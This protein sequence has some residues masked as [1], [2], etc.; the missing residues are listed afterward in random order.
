MLQ[1]ILACLLWSSAFVG[2][3]IGLPYTT[4]LQFAG[5]RFFISGLLV[6]PLAIYFNPGFIGL[7][8][9]HAR[10]LLFIGFLQ[11]FLQYS[12]FYTGIARVPGSIG[13]IVIGSS[14]LFIGIVA[15]FFIP[16][17]KLDLRKILIILFG[18]SGIVL[19]SLGRY[20]GVEGTIHLLGIL[21]LIGN[22]IISGITNVMISLEKKKV[23][24]LVL[25]SVSMIVGGI[26]LFLFSIP[27]E[28]LDLS[29]K[30]LPY[31]LSLGWLS[32][33]SAVAI[34]LWVT[35]LKKP[36]VMVSDLNLWKFLIPVV[37]AVLAWVILPD[38]SPNRI[39]IAGMVITGSS[40]LI[41]TLSSRKHKKSISPRKPLK[42]S[43]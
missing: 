15:H 31:Y 6:L 41:F 21:I 22:N 32:L 4:P 11:T 1:A 16:E 40:L 19:V 26:A 29:P 24:P 8:R 27:L 30:P 36:E 38:E 23:P 20:E 43:V 9:K 33:L 25:S 28:G 7:V 2:I 39:S 5:I 35:L 42:E 13:A 12:L 17:D 18:F 10:F 3:K 34:S 37:G 14:P